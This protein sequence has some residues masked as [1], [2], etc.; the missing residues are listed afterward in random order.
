MRPVTTAKSFITGAY[1]DTAAFNTCVFSD[2]LV[3]INTSDLAVGT[4][5]GIGVHSAA[6][7]AWI[8][9]FD[10]ENDGSG[11]FVPSAEN[12]LHPLAAAAT[13]EVTTRGTVV[14]E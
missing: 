8:S 14:P 1:H 13:D 7:I 9:A 6:N 11:G 3:R 4:A 5:T 10:R 12:A 2:C